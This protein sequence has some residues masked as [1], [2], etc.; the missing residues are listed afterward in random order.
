MS[1]SISNLMEQQ[2]HPP[3]GKMQ[4]DEKDEKVPPPLVVPDVIEMPSRYQ[5][6]LASGD[7]FLILQSKD[8][9]EEEVALIKEYGRVIVFDPMTYM[10]V[11]IH[12]LAFDYMILDL[13]RKEDRI[14]FQ[15]ID[16]SILD[17]YHV[18]SYCYSFQ[19]DDEVHENLDVRNIMTKFPPR[20]A[21]KVD[22]DRLL[23]QKKITKPNSALSC[24]KSL[25]RVV[26][27]DWR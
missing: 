23:R 4:L 14:F 19:K 10:N 20:Q 26:K 8:I 5:V 21:F 3:I 12:T 13:R 16:S 6:P 11:P 2:T 25:L 27:G 22:F 1:I 18:V 15:Q 24:F 17:R 9:D 7:K